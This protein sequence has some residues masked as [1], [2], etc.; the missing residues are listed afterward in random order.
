MQFR[1][2]GLMGERGKEGRERRGGEAGRGR[3]LFGPRE[4]WWWEGA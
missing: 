1:A 3:G 2:A 4:V